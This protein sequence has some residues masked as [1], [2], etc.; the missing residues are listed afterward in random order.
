[1]GIIKNKKC[2]L[3]RI[4]GT[5][6]HI[7]ILSDLNPTIALSEYVREIKQSSSKWLKENPDFPLFEGWAEGYGA[8][9]CGER[10]KDTILQYIANQRE[11]HISISYE[12]EFKRI[13]IENGM[14]IDKHFMK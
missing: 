6:N 12:D 13:L 3:Y 11:H 1:M 4:N 10:T 5:E 14:K 8:F 9:T 2:H 7:H